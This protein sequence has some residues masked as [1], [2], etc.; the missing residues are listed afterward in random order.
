MTLSAFQK[1]VKRHIVGR[2]HN[3]YVSTTPGLESLCHRELRTQLPTLQQSQILENGI[4]CIARLHDAYL[5]NLSL[6]TA[7]R[8]LMRIETFKAA[9]FATLEKKLAAVP[10]ELHIPQGCPLEFR[11]TSRRSRLYHSN[12]IAER[13]KSGIQQRLAEYA[14]R[15]DKPTLPQTLF[16]RAI[17]DRLTLSLD[18]SGDN[19]HR[20]GLKVH[21]SA[22]P[23]RET[24]AA[25]ALMLAD[26]RPP[27]P[28]LDPMCGSGTF[29]I[30]AA[31]M[32]RRVPPGWFR[33]FAFMQWP[34]FGINT[35]RWTYLRNQSESRMI[36]TGPSAI[37]ASD[38]D[39][40]ACEIVRKNAAALGLRDAFS[41]EASDFFDLKA[42]RY[43]R[44]CGLVAVNPPYGRRLGTP[45]E[46]DR[47]FRQIL[48]KLSKD[49]RGW[50]FALIVPRRYLL[51][52]MPFS[53]RTQRVAAGGLNMYITTGVIPT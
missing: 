22:A 50:K 31:M 26:Y 16:A 43:G 1:R 51:N 35:K 20:R 30:E 40:R 29:S 41:I 24:I 11:V 9:N 36:C 10:W 48:N 52:T 21:V 17:E 45:A 19:L 44:R 39:H 27:E 18:S 28:L 37:F 38:T 5:A 13:I 34:A 33:D 15:M 7:N 42:K 25:A 46:S 32:A 6:R 23:L 47:L 3:F 14:P 8:V 49:F 53:F 2:M 4:A 12:A